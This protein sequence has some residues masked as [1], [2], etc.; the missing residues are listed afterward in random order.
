MDV[1]VDD[2]EARLLLAGPVGSAV[3]VQFD[4]EGGVEVHWD[5]PRRG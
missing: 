1:A 4:S 3:G 5:L 2:L